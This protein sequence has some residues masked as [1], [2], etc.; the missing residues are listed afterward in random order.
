MNEEMLNEGMLET[1][2]V[3]NLLPINIMIVDKSVYVLYTNKAFEHNFGKGFIRTLERGPGDLLSCV[4]SFKT[5]EGCGHSDECR[6][7]LLRSYLSESVSGKKPEH[8]QEIPLK[9][10][11][12][13]GEEERWFE[14]HVIPCS[15]DGSEFLVTLIDV[16]VYKKKSLK[17]LENKKLAEAADKTKSEFIANMSHEIRTPLNGV[18]GMIEMT[19]LTNLNEEQRENLEVAKNCADN[20][21]LLINDILDLSK[22]ES[23]KMVLEERPF[24]LR[25]TIQKVADTQ[26]AKVSEKDLELICDVEDR[27][28][29]LFCG[30][31]NKLQQVLNNLVSNAV[32]FTERGKITLE[33]RNLCRLD[34]I[35]TLSFSIEDTGIGIEKEKIV[36]LFKPF[37]QAD[38]SITRKY[39]GT[40]LGLSISQKLV[41]L[42]GGEIKVKSQKDR[43]SVFYFTIQMRQAQELE[44][45][46]KDIFSLECVNK[47]DKILVVEDDSFNQIVIGQILKKLGYKKLIIAENGIDAIKKW[48]LE[49]PDLILMDIVIPELEGNE[50]TRVIREKEKISK[51]HVPIIA[52]T[53]CAMEGDREKFLQQ[54]MD[55]YLSK[56]VDYKQLAS[57]IKNLNTQANIENESEDTL[58]AVYAEWKPVGKEQ[59]QDKNKEISENDRKSF[60]TGISDIYVILMKKEI[61]NIFDAIEKNAHLIK[62]KAQKRGYD[63]IRTC[64]FRMEMASRK[65]DEE[66][67][68]KYCGRIEQIIAQ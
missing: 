3:I 41:G 66:G 28:P 46:D 23:E 8:M 58:K 48:E 52:L 45:E 54:G 26:I 15:K 2:E 12:D 24:D 7:C 49:K 51:E 65:K 63:E 19:M 16:S 64:A 29:Q 21:L 31:A 37:C 22:A 1:R 60:Q 35:Y 42:M 62:V 4:N 10:Q 18:I 14:I 5:Q 53:A 6:A 40:G 39:G 17:L 67:I 36:R 55:G 47:S 44:E 32:K 20:L 9:L 33:V 34:D 57:A 68:R 27:V 38:S 13:F 61:P 56:P 30:D 43:G 25:D 59:E 50:V 11:G